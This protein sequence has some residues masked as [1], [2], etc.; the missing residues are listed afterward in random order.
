MVFIL[1]EIFKYRRAS[2]TRRPLFLRD[3]GSHVVRTTIQHL[4]NKYF[5]ASFLIT[6]NSMVNINHISRTL[7][8]ENFR[9]G[10]HSLIDQRILLYNR[11]F[12]DLF[13]LL[14][15]TLVVI[16]RCCRHKVSIMFFL[17][18]TRKPFLVDRDHPMT[19]VYCDWM[20]IYRENE[21]FNEIF[22]L[23]KS[24]VKSF[25][26]RTNDTRKLGRKNLLLEDC[27]L[28]EIKCW[29]IET[30]QSLLCLLSSTKV[31]VNK[32]RS[33]LYITRTEITHHGVQ[34]ELWN[35]YPIQSI[36]DVFVTFRR[37]EYEELNS[38][39]DWV[40]LFN[41]LSIF[42]IAKQSLQKKSSDII[43]PVPGEIRRFIS[44]GYMSEG[45]SKG[46]TWARTH[47]LRGCSQIL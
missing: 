31:E 42:L 39:L 14:F 11:L 16:N 19:I 32:A 18:I 5:S 21:K 22:F 45:E 4:Q 9:S 29:L 13:E 43:N 38:G 15:F 33:L 37:C 10:F 24:G 28:L 2:E 40:S 23:Y 41:G 25:S 17:T 20:H 8:N 30:D 7:H 6:L 46:A 3:T 34:V 1:T 35:Y 27:F 44:K 12:N 47:L 36:L 26:L